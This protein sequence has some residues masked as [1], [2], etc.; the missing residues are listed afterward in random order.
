MKLLSYRIK[1]PSLAYTADCGHEVI[2]SNFDV[3]E[4]FLRVIRGSLMAGAFREA[5]QGLC[6]DGV[7]D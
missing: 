4:R 7:D 5:R 3:E 1:V 2:L 6:T